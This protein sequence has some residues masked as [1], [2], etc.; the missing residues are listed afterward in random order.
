MVG[1]TLILFEGLPPL[2]L[3]RVVVGRTKIAF[4]TAK[5]VGTAGVDEALAVDGMVGAI[6]I[7]AASDVGVN[8]VRVC[9]NSS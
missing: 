7:V 4:G 1:T 3:V 9:L 2:S 6:G 8:P 5:A